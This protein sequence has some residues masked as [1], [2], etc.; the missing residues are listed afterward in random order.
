MLPPSSRRSVYNCNFRTSEIRPVVGLVKSGRRSEVASILN[1][2]SD[3]VLISLFKGSGKMVAFPRCLN[4]RVVKQDS[5]V[6]Y[7]V[8]DNF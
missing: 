2:L 1:Y 4:S 5:S 7:Q 6:M 3:S 8:I